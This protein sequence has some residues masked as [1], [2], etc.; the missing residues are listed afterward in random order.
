MEIS[1]LSNHFKIALRNL[2]KNK[3]YSLINIAGLALGLAAFVLVFTYTQYQSTYDLSHPSVD[4]LYRVNQTSIWNPEGGQMSSSAP[5]LAKTL[6]DNVP[7]VIAATRINTPGSRLVRYTSEDGNVLAFNENDIL[8][9]DSNFFDFFDFPLQVGNPQTALKGV[10]KMVISPE[11]AIAVT[12]SGEAT[13]D[14]V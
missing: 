10:N 1:L 11:I 9:A 13:K 12:I 5:P 2:R 14:R 3:F 7:E 8:A 4:Q 6:E